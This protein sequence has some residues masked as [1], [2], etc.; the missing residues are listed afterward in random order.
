MCMAVGSEVPPMGA[1]G[2]AGY[3]LTYHGYDILAL[4]T[5]LSRGHIT[6]V[7][8][9]GRTR[10]GIRGGGKGQGK[11]GRSSSSNRSMGGGGSF[12]TFDGR[13]RW[14]ALAGLWSCLP[15][16]PHDD[17]VVQV[18]SQIGVGKESDIYLAQTESGEEVGRGPGRRRCR[19]YYY[20]MDG[21]VLSRDRERR[22]GGGERRRE[23]A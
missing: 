19:A 7:R 3:R 23:G 14:V 12:I 5:L 16:P 2:C 11:A 15:L 4:R 10:R 17:G 21:C 18:G 9:G 8:G 22:G 13:R 6:A 1:C 20:D